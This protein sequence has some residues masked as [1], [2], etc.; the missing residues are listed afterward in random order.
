MT[1]PNDTLTAS[2]LAAATGVSITTVKRKAKA[3]KLPVAFK[4]P[5]STGAYLFTPDA[6]E[7]LRGAA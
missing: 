2:Q 1:T 4:M 5:G 6:I 3:G 7:V